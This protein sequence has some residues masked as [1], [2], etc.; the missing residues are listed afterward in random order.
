[1]FK[2]NIDEIFKDLPNVFG[3]TE[4]TMAVGYDIDSKDNDKTLRQVMHICHCE[5]KQP[6]KNKFYLSC[7]RVLC[8]LVSRLGGQPDP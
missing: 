2:Q 4:D 8:S 6:D 5:N 1:M 3:I 7:I